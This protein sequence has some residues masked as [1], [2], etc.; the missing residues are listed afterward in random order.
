MESNKLL[1]NCD[2]GESFGLWTMGQDAQVMP[3]IDLTN[4]AC[5]FH[6][7]DPQ[8]MVS[9]IQLALQYEVKIGAHPSYPDLQGF[10]RRSIP[11][12]VDEIINLTIYQIGAL[13]A[14]AQSQGTRIHYVKPHGA[15]YNDMMRDMSIFEGL[16]E[17]VS[18]FHVPLMVL[19]VPDRDR[20]LDIA[21]EYDVPLLFEAFIDRSYLADGSLAA[22]SVK[23]A[24]LDRC[25][26]VINQAK[27]IIHYQ[28]VT[29]LDGE[30]LP[31]EADT[32][33]IHGDNPIAVE[34]AQQVHSLLAK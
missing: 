26:D 27:Q 4:I 13:Q 10:G 19:A 18:Q 20:L 25:E 34:I 1:L 22:R 31:I 33:C 30:T 15:L 28:K 3:Y 8:V 11:M 23:G 7:S 2:M 12:S 29:T 17:A 16:C 21:D 6:A 9:T 5:G 32:L 14:L 24:V